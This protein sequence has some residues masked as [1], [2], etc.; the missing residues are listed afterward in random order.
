MSTSDAKQRAAQ[1]R[2]NLADTLDAI[3]DR[4]NV[5]KRISEMGNRAADAYEKNPLPWLVAGAAGALAVIGAVVW[6]IFSD[7]DRD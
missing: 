7:G 6:A 3:E 5:P 2:A 1:A 4:F